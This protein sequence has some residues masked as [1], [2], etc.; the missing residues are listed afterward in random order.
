[1][2][3][4]TVILI[5]VGIVV[6]VIVIIALIVKKAKRTKKVGEDALYNNTPADSSSLLSDSQ[7]ADYVK[8]LADEY[9]SHWYNILPSNASAE[10]ICAVLKNVA[11]SVANKSQFSQIIKEY[12]KQTNS[13]IFNDVENMLLRSFGTGLFSHDE[14][15]L[16]E[17]KNHIKNLPNG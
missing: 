10:S 15:P 11:Y 7:M 4:G 9:Q 14:G 2:K 6:I 1:M 8:Q 17:I 3:K 16:N 5:N 12:A 13:D